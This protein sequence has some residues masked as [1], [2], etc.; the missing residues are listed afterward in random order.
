MAKRQIFKGLIFGFG[1]IKSAGSGDAQS[2]EKGSKALTFAI[3]GFVLIFSSF[4]IIQ[5]IE[6]ITGI[7]ILKP[8]V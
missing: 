2:L 3:L 8:G 1:I 4:F 5:L 6:T 7:N